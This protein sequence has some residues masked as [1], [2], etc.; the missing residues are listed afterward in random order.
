MRLACLRPKPKL[1]AILSFQSIV[2]PFYPYFHRYISFTSSRLMS[3]QVVS[4]SS[5]APAATASAPAKGKKEKVEEAPLPEYVNHRLRMFESLWN[6][7]LAEQS[8]V[9]KSPIQ[10]KLPDGKVVSGLAHQTTPYDIAKGIS[11]SLA[12]RVIIS[13]VDG[14][15][16]D[17]NL[18]LLSDCSLSLF[19]FDSPEGQHTFWHSS[20]HLLG[21]AIEHQWKDAKLCMG[22]PLEDGGFY[23]DVYMEESKVSPLD[24]KNLEKKIEKLQ[25]EKFQFQRLTLKKEEALEMFKDNKFKQEII[26]NKIPDGGVCTAYRCS[27]LVDLCKG[28]HVPFTSTIK[29]LSITKSSSS[30]WL[31]KAE[32]DTL[33][34]IYGISFPDKKKLKEYQT[35][36]KAAEERD[37]RRIGTQQKL[38]FFHSELSP[39]SC[40]FLP[41]GTRVYNRLI[42]FIRSEYRQRGYSEVIT[43][44]IF[45]CDLFKKSGHYAHYKENMFIFDV[46]KAEWALKPMVISHFIL[47]RFF[48]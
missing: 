7:Q 25:K 20:A 21:A 42:E 18:P 8:A 4:G 6:R 38:F 9:E 33:Q 41:H 13:K 28:P 47:A 45:N 27:D 39:G 36:I 19:E 12:E 35:L 31:G 37:H 24:Y 11:N 30:Y 34:R 44:N 23:Y 22:P 26:S 16:W 17:L 3:E 29:A 43:P 5:S 1:P 46:E 2:T 32:N 10:V 14:Q 15:Y 48:S 40:F